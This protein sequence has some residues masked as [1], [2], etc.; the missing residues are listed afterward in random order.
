MK[1]FS[2]L[3]GVLFSQHITFY[4]SE[5]QLFDSELIVDVLWP[6]INTEAALTTTG[7]HCD[8]NNGMKEDDKAF[9]FTQRSTLNSNFLVY[10]RKDAKI[11]WPS[12]VS[13]LCNK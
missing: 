9:T 13:L 11:A 6:M 10:K 5:R 2:F 4:I 3:F 7:R 1:D 8:S 12:A